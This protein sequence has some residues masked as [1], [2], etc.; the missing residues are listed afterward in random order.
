MVM[1]SAIKFISLIKA[2]FSDL[3]SFNQPNF[4]Q[5]NSIAELNLI[6]WSL[7][8]LIEE[9]SQN[10]KPAATFSSEVIHFMNGI[11]T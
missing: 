7:L 11:S 8:K 4:I 6:S 3:A 1:N 5:F 10:H 9:R 2:G